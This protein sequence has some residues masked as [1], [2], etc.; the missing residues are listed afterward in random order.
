MGDVVNFNKARKAK[1]KADARTAADAN[2]AKFGRTKAEK[3]R[4]RADKARADRLLDGAKI[5]E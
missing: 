4:D 3:D 1:T 5:D 2:R